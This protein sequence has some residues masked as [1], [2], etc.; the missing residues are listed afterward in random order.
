MALGLTFLLRSQKKKIA[1]LLAPLDQVREPPNL[2]RSKTTNK[3]TTNKGETLTSLLF[4]LLGLQSHPGHPPLFFGAS[5]LLTFIGPGTL[6]KGLK[7]CFY[8]WQ[9]IDLCL[10]Q[11]FY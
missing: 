1:G 5:V 9:K 10:D 3:P 6:K 7:F 2:T 4:S 11:G 8:S